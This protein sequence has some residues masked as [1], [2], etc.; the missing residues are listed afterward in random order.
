MIYRLESISDLTSNNNQIYGDIY[1][2]T[3]TYIWKFH[4][5]VEIKQDTLNE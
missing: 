1:I 5:I 3:H 4:S 2:Y